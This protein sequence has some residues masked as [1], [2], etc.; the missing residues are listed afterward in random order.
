VLEDEVLFARIIFLALSLL[1]LGNCAGPIDLSKYALQERDGPYY[2]TSNKY[3]FAKS[4]TDYDGG[5]A[6]RS[7]SEVPKVDIG[8]SSAG[9]TRLS[10]TDIPQDYTSSVREAEK[11]DAGTTHTVRPALTVDQPAGSSW[12]DQDPKFL[13]TLAND[14]KENQILKSKTIICRGC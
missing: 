13:E 3:H 1:V 11:S 2:K 8:R 14:D 4:D 7:T 9:D 12:R 6:L 5:I 10:R